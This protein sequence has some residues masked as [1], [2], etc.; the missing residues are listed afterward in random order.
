MYQC[1]HN[2][3]RGCFLGQCC[4]YLVGNDFYDEKFKSSQRGE[5][6]GAEMGKEKTVH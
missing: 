3:M 1:D 4:C 6:E 5:G 2:L